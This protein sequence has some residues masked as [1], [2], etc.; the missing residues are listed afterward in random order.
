M[1]QLPPKLTLEDTW[2]AGLNDDQYTLAL[3]DKLARL[4]AW[5]KTHC[6]QVV[7]APIRKKSFWDF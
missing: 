4:Q 6:N 1:A 2:V 3:I 5:V 7:S